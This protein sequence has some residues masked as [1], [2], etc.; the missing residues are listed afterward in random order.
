MKHNGVLFDSLIVNH[1]EKI[2]FML[3]MS[4]ESLKEHTLS[5]TVIESVMT[6]L[7]SVLYFLHRRLC[8]LSKK[9]F[10]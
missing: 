4:S 1:N 7:E 10:D 8:D 2:V 9:V 6:E 3:Q 5:A